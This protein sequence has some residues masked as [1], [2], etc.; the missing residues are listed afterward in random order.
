MFRSFRCYDYT[1]SDFVELSNFN[2]EVPDRKMNRL[3]GTKEQH[4]HLRGGQEI[5]SDGSF[6]RVSFKSNSAFD[7]TGFEAFYQ[8]M[9][10]GQN[11]NVYV[12]TLY[13]LILAIVNVNLEDGRW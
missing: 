10:P 12:S 11:N 8:F 1:E 7:A 2:I 4:Q 6:F 13:S 9:K 5:K 3:C